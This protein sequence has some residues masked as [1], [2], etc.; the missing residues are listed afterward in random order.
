MSQKKSPSFQSLREPFPFFE[1]FDKHLPH[2]IAGLDDLGIANPIVNIQPF[3]TS[4]DNP[5]LAQD[6][7]MLGHIGFGNSKVID[8]L[9]DSQFVIPERFDDLKT[10]R[11][12]ENLA[13]FGVEFEQ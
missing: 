4:H 9:A 7:E 2:E 8:N 5:L 13:H 6:R 10:L 3:S 1:L 11:V 12:R